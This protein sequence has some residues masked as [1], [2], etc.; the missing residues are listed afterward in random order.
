MP[1]S[2]ASLVAPIKGVESRKIGGV[3]LDVM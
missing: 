1:S 2:A 3:Q